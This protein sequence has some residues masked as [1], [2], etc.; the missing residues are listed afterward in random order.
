MY[1]YQSI[2]NHHT[3]INLFPYYFKLDC[4]NPVDA[5]KEVKRWL[6]FTISI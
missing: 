2:Q 3:N 1:Q 4:H 5:L 6:Y